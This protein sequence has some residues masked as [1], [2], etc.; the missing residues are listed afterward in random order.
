M[1]N[2]LEH[3]EHISHANHD[4]E[5][6]SKLGTY[7]GITMAVLGV[8]LAYCAAKVGAE[9]TELIQALVEQQH[10]H[11]KYQA[12]DIK[13]RVAVSNLRQLHA[14]I[15]TA[16][17]AAHLDAELRKIDDEAAAPQAA[18]PTAGAA[19]PKV[20]KAD[21]AAPRAEGAAVAATTRAARAL[22]RNVAEGMTPSKADAAILADNVERYANESKAASVWV[23][24]FDP[25]I[26][27]HVAAQER[28][29]L[30]QLLAEIGIVIASVALLVKRRL[31]WFAALGLGVASLGYVGTTLASTGQVVHEAEGKIEELGKEYRDLRT[32][33]KALEADDALIAEVRAWTGTSGPKAAPDHHAPVKEAHH[34]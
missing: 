15:P 23:E 12:Q 4:H 19:A 17:L 11:A 10:A 22:G 34:E 18:A 24:A 5:E 16:E 14:E 7:I 27:A 13:H 3:A 8:V 21:A 30:A 6:H 9:R 32:R 1:T 33:D 28:F 25:A 20:D 26:H 29:E 31:P 2:P